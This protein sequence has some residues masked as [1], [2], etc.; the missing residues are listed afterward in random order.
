MNKRARNRLIGVTA[1]IL[2]IIAA[3]FFASSGGKSGP[4]YY[5][6]VTEIANSNGSL[7]GT[8]VTVGGPVVAG[9]WDKKTHPMRFSISDD[10]DKSSKATLKVVY[11]GAVPNTFGDG[12]V[13]IVDGTL[14][15]DGTVEATALQTKCPE[16]S[17]SRAGAITVGGLLAA[18][19]QLAGLPV[20]VS[21]AVV[22]N[23]LVPPGSEVRFAI[24]GKEAT[25][26]LKVKFDGAPPAGFKDG[27]Q[28]VLGGSLDASGGVFDA[29]SVSLS[30]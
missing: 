12:V 13:A 17:A 9:S 10:K 15:K 8:N 2:A 18:Q 14:T 22:A 3:F 29:T 1:I 21:G 4:A 5:K 24:Q 19:K 11:N 30:K 25:A 20:K 7:V 28:V 26:T 23:S 16:K 6:T 27:A